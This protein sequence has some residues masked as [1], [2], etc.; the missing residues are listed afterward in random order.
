MIYTD[1]LCHTASVEV[2]VPAAVA[3]EYM[4]DGIRQG[5]WTL[6]SWN[7]VALSD[8]LFKGTSLYDGSETYVRIVPNRDLLI[9]DY[10]IGKSAENLRPINSARIIDGPSIGRDEGA[11][12]VTLMRWRPGG[13]SDAEA[14]RR[15]VGFNAEMFMIKGRLELGF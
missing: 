8:N 3:F 13:E 6:G 14:A 1:E 2:E 9:V 5:E 4:A 10:H 7:R 15:S 12:I 11:C